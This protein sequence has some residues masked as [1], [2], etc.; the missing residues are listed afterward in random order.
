VCQWDQFPGVV[1]MASSDM[2]SLIGITCRRLQKPLPGSGTS[3]LLRIA[4][5]LR[6]LG[7]FPA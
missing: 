7:E 1:W 2:T 5:L 6:K 3:S 4:N